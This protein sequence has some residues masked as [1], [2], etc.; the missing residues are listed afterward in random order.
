MSINWNVPCGASR[1][2]C[3]VDVPLVRLNIIC[4]VLRNC[5]RG[6][7]RSPNLVYFALVWR[8][9][10]SMRGVAKNKEQR[11]RTRD[12]SQVHDA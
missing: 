5:M 6:G 1:S 7:S 2:L 9:V 12:V 10:E 11:N 4:I 8:S 3:T